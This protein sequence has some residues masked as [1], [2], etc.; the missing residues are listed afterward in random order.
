[1]RNILPKILIVLLMSGGVLQAQNSTYPWQISVSAS[2][3]DVSSAGE[4]GSRRIQPQGEIFD[5]F[6]NVGDHWNLGGPTISLSRRIKGGLSVGVEG[7]VNLITKVDG[8]ENIEFPF[9][10]ASA[11]AKFSPLQDKKISPYISGG[12]GYASVDQETSSSLIL[13]KNISQMLS[14]G[15]GIDIR[16]AE[17]FKLGIKSTF[18]NPYERFGVDHFNHTLGVNY[19]FGAK[20]SDKDGIIDEK[21]KCPQLPGL[22]EYDGCPDTDEDTIPDNEDECPEEPGSVELKGCPDSDGDGTPDKD[23]LC[24]DVVGPTEMS[25]CPDSDMDEVHDGIDECP[26]EVGPA[27]NNGCPLPDTDEDGVPDEQDKCPEEAGTVENEGCPPLSNEIM[28]TLNKF[29]SNI[30]FPAQSARIMGKKP[31]QTLEKIKALLDENPNG[32]LIIEGYASS[33][34]DEEYN[35]QLSQQRAEAVRDYL[36][37]LGVPAERL[38]VVSFGEA[39]PIGD[40]ETAEGRAQNRRVQFK[41]K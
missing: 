23:D 19:L 32:K 7:T 14:G 30:N 38:E 12:W 10:S 4:K 18:N 11:F 2:A 20:D 21:D 16:L 26:E 3:I 8:L 15:I 5:D 9:Y 29:G 27:S 35:L 28:S 39:N 40:D 1:M 25:G 17:R 33:D 41:Q 34:G 22:K 13:S 6:L 37:E 24:P 31:Q 36:I